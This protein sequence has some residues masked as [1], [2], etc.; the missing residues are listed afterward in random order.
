MR[1]EGDGP[2]VFEAPGNR[3]GAQGLGQRGHGCQRASTETADDDCGPGRTEKLTDQ[4]TLHDE[5][6]DSVCIVPQGS[7][8]VR[9]I[10]LGFCFSK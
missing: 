9:P 2:G 5:G 1:Q 4:R 10:G 3:H 7:C 6:I 8:A